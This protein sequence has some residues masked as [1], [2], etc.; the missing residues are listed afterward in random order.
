MLTVKYE[1]CVCLYVILDT[2]I[3]ITGKLVKSGALVGMNNVIWTGVTNVHV[4]A[5]MIDGTFTWT[6]L[7]FVQKKIVNFNGDPINLLLCQLDFY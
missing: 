5:C 3:T 1:L 4:A 6:R 2:F 7:H